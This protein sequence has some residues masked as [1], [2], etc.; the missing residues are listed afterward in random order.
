MAGPM[1]PG[2]HASEGASQR[3]KGAEAGIGKHRD[4]AEEGE[5]G[6]EEPC[7]LLAILSILIIQF[8]GYTLAATYGVLDLNTGEAPPASALTPPA[9][10][11]PLAM[12]SAPPSSQPSAAP[13]ATCERV[14]PTFVASCRLLCG[15]SPGALRVDAGCST[16]RSATRALSTAACRPACSRRAR[17]RRWWPSR[18]TERRAASL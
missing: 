8:Q 6:D 12:T 2:S 18:R 16:G 13:A 17:S 7:V 10:L 14:C 15:S 3:A 9:P 5:P 11:L 1:Q 4:A